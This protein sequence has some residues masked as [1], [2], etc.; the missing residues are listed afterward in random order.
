MAANN[1]FRLTSDTA[2]LLF[3]ALLFGSM[4]WM[5]GLE[6]LWNDEI[7]TLQFFVLKGLPSV[8]G[9][10]HVPNNHILSNVLHWGWL[11]IMGI[12]TLDPLLD[13]AWKIRIL[14]GL[15]SIGTLYVLYRCGSLLAG[16]MAAWAA[17]IM[18]LTTLGFGNFAFQV[19]GYPLTMLL[20]A[21]LFYGALRVLH[22]EKC[23]WKSWAGMASATAALLYTI[24][25]NLYAV[26]ATGALLTILTTWKSVPLGLKVASAFATGAVAAFTWYL[27]ILDHVINSEYI[28]TGKPLQAVHFKNFKI[29]LSHIVSWRFLLLPMIVWGI[30]L[31]R[32]DR[33]QRSAL[34]FFA[35]V[36]LLPFL[37]SAL[38]GDTPP[39]RSF[40]VLVPALTLFAAYAWQASIKGLQHKKNLDLLLIGASI[41]V[42]L[43][44]YWYDYH[45]ARQRIEKGMMENRAFLQNINCNY[46]QFYYCPNEE[47]D[48]FK[49]KKGQSTLV[50]HSAEA[51]DMPLYLKRK[52][53]NFV[54][55]DSIYTRLAN[56]NTLFVSTRYPR[57]F[58]QNLKKVDPRWQCSYLQPK[59]RYTRIIVCQKQ[60]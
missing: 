24:P 3:C 46:Y 23:D 17:V 25:S 22:F 32:K 30:W 53:I 42:C 45:D 1:S 48:L 14:P 34:I 27:P 33:V 28:Q 7:Y 47:Y 41:L 43:F 52:G 5:H 10:Y 60:E 26:V 35:G 13:N 2:L 58:I 11:R 31:I 9:D 15:L 57:N 59:V 8:L 29:V 16:K 39:P 55:M 38:R 4:V 20:S 56:Q 37:I 40:L 19:R 18:L 6:A 44:T 21:L 36:F 54:P 50:L 51:Y 12:S 49:Q